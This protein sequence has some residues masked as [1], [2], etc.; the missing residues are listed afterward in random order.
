MQWELGKHDRSNTIVCTLHVYPINGKPKKIFEAIT[1]II[2]NRYMPYRRCLI[3]IKNMKKLKIIYYK[4]KYINVGFC[5]KK[6][7]EHE[8]LYLVVGAV[9]HYNILFCPTLKFKNCS[10]C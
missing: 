1:Y 3:N 7:D 10:D 6:N 9:R 4:L 8:N 2:E 5:S